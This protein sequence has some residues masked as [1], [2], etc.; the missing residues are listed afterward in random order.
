MDKIISNAR[1]ILAPTGA[2]WFLNTRHNIAR[3][4]DH[5]SSGGE[6]ILRG[7]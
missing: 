2:R 3:A 6:V 4:G 1:N 5:L 7:T